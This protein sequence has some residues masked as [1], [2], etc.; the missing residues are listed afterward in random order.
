MHQ[1][2]ETWKPFLRGA[3]TLGV[4]HDTYQ[5]F[6]YLVS[7][8]PDGAITDLWFS[9]YKDMRPTGGRLKMGYR[10]GGP[11]V[12]GSQDLLILLQRLIAIGAL[13]RADLKKVLD[14]APTCSAPSVDGVLIRP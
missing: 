10:P 6:V 12:L 4:R 13:S 9:Y 14:K 1:A 5:P 11:P 2:L 8:K 3:I 7:Y